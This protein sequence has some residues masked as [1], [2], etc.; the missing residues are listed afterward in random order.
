[1]QRCD[2]DGANLFRQRV[3]LLE[4]LLE[5]N[6]RFARKQPGQLLRVDAILIFQENSN[7]H[8]NPLL[9]I[10][11]GHLGHLNFRVRMAKRGER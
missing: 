7:A 5:Y 2:V 10:G 6:A 3:L 11:V 8:F 9:G 4:Q 1:M